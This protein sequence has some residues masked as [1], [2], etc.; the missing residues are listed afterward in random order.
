MVGRECT[1]GD[2]GGGQCSPVLEGCSYILHAAYD[3][4][5][6]CTWGAA[7]R[8]TESP[9]AAGCGTASLGRGS[10]GALQP[11]WPSSPGLA[12]HTGPAA[13]HGRDRSCH[14]RRTRT[15]VTSAGFRGMAAGGGEK[16]QLLGEGTG[17]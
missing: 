14:Q 6:G 17:R 10:A 12:L 15:G 5:L 7:S 2:G 1:E 11:A 8:Y 4:P 13:P 16:Q 9:P 3:V